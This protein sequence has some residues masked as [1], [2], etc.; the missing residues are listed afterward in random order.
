MAMRLHC[1]ARRSDQ[2]GVAI[3]EFALVAVVFFTVLLGIMDFGRMLFTW[4]SAAEATRWG[5]RLAVVCDMLDPAQVR[6]RMRLILPL[7]TD[8]N[9]VITW[10]NPEGTPSACD[11]TNCKAVEV[12]LANFTFTPLSPFMGFVPINVPDFRTYLPRESMEAVN[13]AMDQNPVCFM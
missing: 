10:F 12:K 8:A 7:L 1:G 11:K 3:V 9:I 2:L 5:A 6:D 4:N 13:A